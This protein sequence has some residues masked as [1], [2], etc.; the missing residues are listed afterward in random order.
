MKSIKKAFGNYN[1]SI[2]YN[3][4]SFDAYDGIA[5]VCLV[6]GKHE[7]AVLNNKKSIELARACNARQWMLNQ[8]IAT[9][10]LLVLSHTG[11]KT[12]NR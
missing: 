6:R 11:R 2:K 8:L 10:A 1:K 3:S 12:M 7:N 4:S 5:K 9:I